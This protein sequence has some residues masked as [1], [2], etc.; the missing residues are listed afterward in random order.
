[1]AKK[2]QINVSLPKELVD[3]FDETYPM[4]GSKTWFIE[5]ALRKFRELHPDVTPEDL[6]KEGMKELNGF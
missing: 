3:W 1:M 5:E 4:H 6:V 2:R